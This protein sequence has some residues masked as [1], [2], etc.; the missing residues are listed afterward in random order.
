MILQTLI[1]AILQVLVLTLI[2]FLVYVISKKKLKG[3]LS[4]IGLTKPLK[5]TVYW[6][7][8][9]TVIIALGGSLIPLISPEIKE[10][11]TQKGSVA[12]NL[13]LMGLSFETVIVLLIIALIQTSLSEEIF[14]RG[15]IAKRLIDWLGF[16]PGNT[17][18]AMIFGSLHFV[19]LYFI[20][21]AP[22]YFLVF[23]FI[24]TSL[25]GYILGYIKE[26]LGNGSIIPGWIVHGTGNMISFFL[27]A[28][29]I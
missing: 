6:A 14:F 9:A 4:Y 29:I 19:L 8:L 12:G 18:Q 22:G 26:R 20:G 5:K 28:F 17:I 25:A 16:I 3:F 10:L 15:F 23:V 27:V 24:L 7:I 21:N 13:K 2:P 11:M 1:F